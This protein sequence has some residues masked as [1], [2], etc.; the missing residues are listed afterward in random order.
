MMTDS[1]HK[2]YATDQL[3]ARFELF[4]YDGNTYRKRED[5]DDYHDVGY[6]LPSYFGGG[7]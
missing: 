2:K 5:E 7:Q 1:W 4:G 6:G 3:K